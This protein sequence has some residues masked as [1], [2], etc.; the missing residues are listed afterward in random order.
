MTILGL[1]MIYE[2]VSFSFTIFWFWS[3][4]PATAAVTAGSLLV[5]VRLAR[6]PQI[7]RGTNVVHLFKIRTVCNNT[8]LLVATKGHKQCWQRP[9]A[10]VENHRGRIINYLNRH[11]NSHSAYLYRY[12]QCITVVYSYATHVRVQF[13]NM[14]YVIKSHKL[15]KSEAMLLCV[16]CRN[17]FT[18]LNVGYSERI[19]PVWLLKW[20]HSTGFYLL[21]VSREPDLT[22]NTAGQTSP[23]VLCVSN[24]LDFILNFHIWSAQ[25][26]F[27]TSPHS[28]LHTE[29]GVAS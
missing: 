8:V 4:S 25:S 5:S 20:A 27:K 23:T 1:M 7:Y 22:Q 17:G 14:K 3:A 26:F 6:R 16:F 19:V 15:C 2:I 29:Q 11:R 24:L 13:M 18:I 9:A 28:N 10:S 12:Q 21:S